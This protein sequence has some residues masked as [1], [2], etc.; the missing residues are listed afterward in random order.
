MTREEFEKKFDKYGGTA[1][2]HDITIYYDCY[3]IDV[4]NGEEVVNFFNEG[5]YSIMCCVN[6]K[7]IDLTSKIHEEIEMLKTERILVHKQARLNIFDRIA[8]ERK[9]KAE[10]IK[11]FAERLLNIFYPKLTICY[12]SDT[13][14]KYEIDNIVKE[15]VGEEYE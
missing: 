9:A 15:M 3:T 7:D 12:Y 1:I 10:A 2:I 8:I 6:L 13:K 14:I 4:E 11:D 5:G